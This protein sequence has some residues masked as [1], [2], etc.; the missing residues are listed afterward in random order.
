MKVRGIAAGLSVVFKYITAFVLTDIFMHAVVNFMS[1]WSIKQAC[2][3]S[4][5]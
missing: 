4:M 5:V 2:V 3:S 1:L